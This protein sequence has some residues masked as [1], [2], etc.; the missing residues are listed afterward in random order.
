MLLTP[1][2]NRKKPSVLLADDD[3]MT[4]KAISNFLSRHNYDVTTVNDGLEALECSKNCAYDYL[5]TDIMM[6]EVEGIEVISEII[7]HCPETKIIAIS[8]DGIA[9]HSTLLTLAQT[10][11][12]SATLQKP[13][14]PDALIDV[15]ES[16]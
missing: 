6:P 3:K 8:S 2:L 15:M 7:E 14:T 13:V 11:G 12:A 5:I 16:L 4:C 9:G 10:V 1:V